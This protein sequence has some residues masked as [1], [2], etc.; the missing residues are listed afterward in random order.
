MGYTCPCGKFH[1]FDAW[2]LAHQHIRLVHVCTDCGRKN[3]VFKG[4]VKNADRP[5]H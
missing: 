3:D 2:A 1:K 5:R 4:K